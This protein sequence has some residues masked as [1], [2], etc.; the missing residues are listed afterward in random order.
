MA[1]GTLLAVRP[2]AS[3]LAPPRTVRPDLSVMAE[4][5][6]DLLGSFAQCTKPAVGDGRPVVTHTDLVE[7]LL[8]GDPLGQA[9]PDLVMV[10][11]A[12]PDVH[13]F[14]TTAT[15]LAKRFG[16]RATSF[17]VAEQ[18][19]SA[20]FSALR[21]A[22][23]YHRL[24][25]VRQAVLAILEQTTL[26]NHDPVVDEADLVDSGVLLLLESHGPGAA[27]GGDG[28]ADGAALA[29]QDVWAQRPAGECVRRLSAATGSG[30]GSTLLVEG[31]L[32][33]HGVPAQ[34]HG[35]DL[36]RHTGATY[37][38]SVWL[39]LAG[40][41]EWHEQYDRIV[42][43]DTDPRSGTCAGAVLGSGPTGPRT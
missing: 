6:H 1:A 15:T 38:T 30:E 21:I 28:A 10:A 24:G 40:H 11:Y 18:G 27:A 34:H 13:P 7:N 22:A 23:A 3:V 19:L 14:T 5:D 37:C 9:D 12:L 26:P 2:G 43:H 16:N 17:A 35:V 29:V 20:P 33:G 41:P 8:D 4:Y 25:H 32:S 36:H 31:P 39:A 42:L